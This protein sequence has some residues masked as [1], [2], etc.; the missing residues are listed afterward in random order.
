M[1]NVHR[2]ITAYSEFRFHARD[3]KNRLPW[4]SYNEHFK[5]IEIIDDHLTFLKYEVK[6]LHC[7]RSKSLT[8]DTRSPSNLKKTFSSKIII[9][10][11]KL[12]VESKNNT[13]QGS[14]KMYGCL[15]FSLVEYPEF[16]LFYK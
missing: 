13:T 1:C 7:I 11:K 2:R 9:A 15:P 8:A 16:N 3:G 12:N 14:I 5:I 6:C 10:K 4:N